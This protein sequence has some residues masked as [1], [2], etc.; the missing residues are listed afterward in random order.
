MD[1]M[2]DWCASSGFGIATLR[3]DRRVGGFIKYT[4]ECDRALV[5]RPSKAFGLRKTS[6]RRNCPCPFRIVVQRKTGDGDLGQGFTARA[7][8]L[9]H[10][11]HPPSHSLGQHPLFRRQRLGPEHEDFLETL[12]ADRSISARSMAYQFNERYGHIALLT[13]KDIYNIRQEGRLRDR[14][15]LSDIGAFVGKLR[16][17]EARG[18]GWVRFNWDDDGE[19][20]LTDVF[21]AHEPQRYGAF[22]WGECITIDATYNVDEKQWPLV[23]GVIVTPEKTALPIFQARLSDEKA[24]G[25]IWLVESIK[26]WMAAQNIRH[27][28]V[29]ITDGDQQLTDAL[30]ELFPRVQRQRCVWHLN[31]NLVTSI[32]KH[33]AK[34]KPPTPP[35]RMPWDSDDEG[36]GNNGEVVQRAA[37][38]EAEDLQELNNAH[39]KPGTGARTKLILGAVPREVCN[40]R[41]GFFRLWQHMVFSDTD[42]EFD[43]AF[44]LMNRQ[45]GNSQPILWAYIVNQH[46][47]RKTEWAGCFTR[48]YR[49]YGARTT[50]ANESTNGSVKSYGLSRKNGFL[51]VFQTMWQHTKQRIRA[52]DHR[53]NNSA[54]KIR[55]NYIHQ[56][57]LG[58]TPFKLSG[59][60]MD[61]LYEQY[62]RFLT[63]VPT[64]KKPDATPTHCTGQFLEAMGLP[65][66]HDMYSMYMEKEEVLVPL[67]S[68]RKFWHTDADVR[69]PL[70]IKALLTMLFFY[71]AS[72]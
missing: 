41:A 45:F 35:E 22:R 20:D 58:D 3:S 11:G 72:S 12:R 6:T 61:Q 24:R 17:L 27:P 63:F 9:R 53:Q 46:L 7:V 33:W 10:E 37:Q 26:L 8:D 2:R 56:A 55:L 28:E 4:I 21:W 44:D 25:Y 66:A 29:F 19:T 59:W 69:T 67:A 48:F 49:N 5:V 54:T 70:A 16:R 1:E 40:T 13:D 43:M 14:D 39:S 42:E 68:C 51:E 52:F 18:R 62:K 15:G 23:I 50:S 36:E 64:E 38:E 71:T 65:C 34:P 30:D 32:K 60:G 31:C 47:P 57:W